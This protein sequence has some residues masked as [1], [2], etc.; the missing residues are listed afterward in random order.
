M[1]EEIAGGENVAPGDFTAVSNDHADDALIL[2]TGSGLDKASLH[3]VHEVIDR[4]A[5]GLRNVNF[6]V[7][8]SAPITGDSGLEILRGYLWA[9]VRWC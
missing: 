7:G 4:D 1:I 6:F 2:Q 8:F 9:W 3:F 5:D